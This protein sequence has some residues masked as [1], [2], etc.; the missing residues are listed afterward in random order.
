MDSK[1]IPAETEPEPTQNG[2]KSLNGASVIT[3][4]KKA[5]KVLGVEFA[6]ILDIPWERRM[7]TVSVL[8]WISAFFLMG[9]VSLL[10]LCYLYMF[11]Q[12]GFI[13]LLYLAWY[14]YDRST[15]NRG[16]RRSN[17]V[18]RW[19]IWKRYCAYFPI[20][21]V[22]TTDLDP[23]KNYLF[24]SHPH[25][26]LCSGAFGAF[27]TEGAGVSQLFPGIDMHLLTLEGHYSLPI[28]REYL[29][30]S[31]T[32]SASKES[33]NYLLSRKEGGHA[34]IVVVGG[35]PESLDSHPGTYVLQLKKRKGFIKMAIR[36][37]SPLVP[38]FSFG[39]TDIYD[40]VANPEGSLLRKFQEK[41]QK[42]A[43]LAPVLIIGRGIFQ[44]SFGLLPQRRPIT[45]IVGAPILV[46]DNREP[47]Q[48]EIDS[49]HQKYMDAV[50]ELYY[51]HR[52]EYG[53]SNVELTIV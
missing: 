26:V 35:A 17:W 30:C 21:L 10:F 38:V 32:V 50:T 27:A 51:K 1:I 53:D 43:G 44:Y 20:K 37:G 6:P 29:M 45:I 33:L 13:S 36:H 25:G 12:F 23:Q 49:V 47:S 39:E 2:H 22:K 34:A 24:G 42:M 19:K 16:G 28:Y 7:Q 46:K 11:T 52:D 48:E 4:S 5:K 18:R 31:G 3:D 41:W 40:Q 14:L 8:S 15:C 9:P